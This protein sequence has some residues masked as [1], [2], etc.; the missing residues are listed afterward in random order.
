MNDVGFRRVDLVD[1]VALRRAYR[2][3]VIGD[4]GGRAARDGS[5]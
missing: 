1:P 3:A 2:R 4:S 5:P